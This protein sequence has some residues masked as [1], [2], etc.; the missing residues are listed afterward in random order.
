MRILGTLALT[1][2][3]AL[4]AVLTVAT[5]G[6][7][8]AHAQGFHMPDEAQVEQ[9]MDH[10]GVSGEQRQQMRAIHGRF[11]LDSKQIDMQRSTSHDALTEAIFDEDF[12][13]TTIRNAAAELA[14]VQADEFVTQARMMQEVRRVLTPEQYEKLGA[15][16]GMM[17]HGHG[18]SV[19]HGVAAAGH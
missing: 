17:T 19:S 15:A 11:I 16:H 6:L 5:G 9:L 1:L 3:L 12:D 8:V 4:V 2:S 7:P 18:Y 14:A 10:I 13:E